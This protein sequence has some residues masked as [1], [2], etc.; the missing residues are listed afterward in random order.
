M[1]SCEE[2]VRGMEAVAGPG[3]VPISYRIM[4]Q[5][6]REYKIKTNHLTGK[7]RKQE[8][9]RNS[10][11]LVTFQSL[12]DRYV[13]VEGYAMK[14]GLIPLSH[15]WVVDLNDGKAI[16]PTWPE[17]DGIYFGVPFDN[18]FV[19]DFSISVGCYGIFENLYKLHRARNIKRLED[20]IKYL[21]SGIVK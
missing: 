8:C 5:Y 4:A 6:G 1:N 15:A 16:D 18:E 10:E 17:G 12:D 11:N 14:P 20:V 9:Y 21:E 19:N 13:Y 7:G 3:N 2:L